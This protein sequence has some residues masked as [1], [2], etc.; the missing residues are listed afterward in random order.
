MYIIINFIL[1]NKRSSRKEEKIEKGGK[2]RNEQEMSF[3]E[4]IHKRGRLWGDIS[5]RRKTERH[6]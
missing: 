2:R 3:R 4:R 5:K 6:L 1:E